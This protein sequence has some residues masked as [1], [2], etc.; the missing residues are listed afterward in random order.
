MPSRTL[1]RL[2]L[3]L[4]CAGGTVVL[5][6]YATPAWAEPASS[7]FS[8]TVVE[9]LAPSGVVAGG[10]KSTMYVVALNSDGSPIAGLRGKVT[11]DSGMGGELTDLGGGSYSFPFTPGKSSGI[12]RLGLKTKLAGSPYWVLGASGPA[13]G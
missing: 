6:A 1:V 3:G 10:P 12:A 9:L 8:G 11:S 2:A 13:A 5:A 7:A 4:A